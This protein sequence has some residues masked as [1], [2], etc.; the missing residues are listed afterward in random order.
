MHGWPI[1]IQPEP[2]VRGRRLLNLHDPKNQVN[3]PPRNR[4]MFFYY[5]LVSIQRGGGGLG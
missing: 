3:R 1:T 4:S 5:I 2:G